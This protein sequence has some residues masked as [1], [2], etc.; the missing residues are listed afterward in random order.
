[1]KVKDMTYIAIFAALMAICAWISIP[2]P[3]PFTLQTFAVFA[4]VGMLG[5][6]RGTIAVA[7]YILLGAVGLPVF[8]GFAGGPGALLGM[9]GGY[10]FGFLAAALVMWG[11]T[12]ILG[13]GV[14]PLGLAMLLGL[15]ACYALGTVWFMDVY[16]RTKGAIT[17]LA[18][19]SK[20]VFPFVLPDLVKIGLALLVTF[21]VK[22]LV[23]ALA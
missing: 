1:M 8:S 10:I 20:C 9:T 6:K 16:I 11:V 23:P 2:A 5:G 12:R 13:N 14:W 19:L 15:L 17:L 18:V 7:V 3:V 4:A 21:R 22:K